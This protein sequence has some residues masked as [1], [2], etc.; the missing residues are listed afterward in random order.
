MPV[1]SNIIQFSL[2]SWLAAY[3]ATYKPTLDCATKMAFVI[4]ASRINIREGSGGPFAAAVFKIST[5]ELVALGVNCVVTGGMSILHAEIVAIAAAQK[6]L[7][8][9]DLADEKVVDHAGCELVTSSEP[10]A[11]CFG[12]IPWSGVR[13]VVTGASDADVRKLGFDEGPKM[14]D[15]QAQLQLRNIEVVANVLRDAAT[16]VLNAYVEQ[17]GRIYNSRE[18]L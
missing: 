3:S 9:Y 10:C 14:H 5:G 1:A 11:M 15:W 17:N 6:K 12:A 4:E 18:N 13:R 2:P 7:G 16:D 8:C